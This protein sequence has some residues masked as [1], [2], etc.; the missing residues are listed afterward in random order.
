MKD[1]FL[2]KKEHQEIFIALTNEEA[3]ELIKGIFNY[4]C[5]G[6]SGLKGVL[7]AVFVP[8]KKVIDDNEEKYKKI[9]ERNKQNGANGGRPRNSEEN[10]ENPLGYV[11]VENEKKETQNNPTGNFGENTHISYI[12]NQE[13]YNHNSNLE[14]IGCGKEEPLKADDSSLLLETTKKVVAYLNEKTDSN[15]RYSSKATQTKV[16]ARLNEKYTLIDFITVI[17]KKVK[18]WTGTEF[19]KYLCPETLFGTKFEKY[20]NQ[21]ETKAKP[22]TKSD[23]QMEILKGVYDETI[24]IS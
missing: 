11:G 8:I 16:N 2:L 23:K 5:T 14:E 9:C 17:D 6:D 24:K 3:G 15:F 10:Q 20:L 21:K 19:E 4:V 22:Q 1:N 7:N 12:T 13:S 18:E